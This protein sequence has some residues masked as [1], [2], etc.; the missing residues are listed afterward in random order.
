MSTYSKAPSAVIEM[1]NGVLC[2][3]EIHRPILDAKVRIDYL[4]AHANDDKQP[5]IMH[6]GHPAIGRTRK[7]SQMDRVAGRGDAEILLDAGWWL[8][9]EKP[10]KLAL[11]DHELHH[12]ELCDGKRDADGRPVLKIR[13]HDVEIGWFSIIAQRHGADSMECQQAQAIFD[14]YGQAFWPTLAPR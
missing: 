2:E 10:Q 6:H 11:L 4:F 8:T 1:A 5:A 13:K 9:A 14:R 3:F 7:I 12:I